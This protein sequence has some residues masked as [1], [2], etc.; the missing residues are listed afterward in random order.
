MAKQLTME[1]MFLNE[2]TQPIQYVANVC[3]LVAKQYL[4]RSKRLKVKPN[5]H[6]FKQEITF[7]QKIVV[8]N[9]ITKQGVVLY[10]YNLRGNDNISPIEEA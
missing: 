3:I 8:Y 10:G 4:F 7:I 2:V 9:A 1:S 5:M 6:G